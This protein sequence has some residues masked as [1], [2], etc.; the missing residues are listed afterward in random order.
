MT[1]AP[2]PPPL[3]LPPVSSLTVTPAQHGGVPSVACVAPP[4][5]PHVVEPH[6]V[7]PRVVEPRVVATPSATHRRF[8]AHE[9]GN[10]SRE[11]WKLRRTGDF[12]HHHGAG[13]RNGIHGCGSCELRQC[14]MHTALR[15]R[16]NPRIQHCFTNQCPA[17][18][19][20][21]PQGGVASGQPR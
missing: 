11:V 15:W 3:A 18:A 12:R 13:Y 19:Q 21:S 8:R 2:P 7:E 10:P 4:V 9:P 20:A 5:E 14:S 16:R 1:D 17:D 6:V